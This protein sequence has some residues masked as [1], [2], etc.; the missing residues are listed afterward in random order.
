MSISTNPQTNTKQG[1]VK[2]KAS[3]PCHH[4]SDVQ[5][6]VPAMKSKALKH[7]HATSHVS[8]EVQ[9]VPLSVIYSFHINNLV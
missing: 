2:S 5:N 8:Q 7:L 3:A 9:R 4:F 6:P 1:W